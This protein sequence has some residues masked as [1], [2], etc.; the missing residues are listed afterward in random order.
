[1]LTLEPWVTIVLTTSLRVNLISCTVA[2]ISL[3]AFDQVLS[4]K[5]K[6]LKVIGGMGNLIGLKAK[7]FDNLEDGREV[8]LFFSFR[9]G[10]VVAEIALATVV[11]GEAEVDGD[12]FAMTD[13]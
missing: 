8:A 5:I 4:E 6:T 13:M 2:D 7:P 3:S 10:V 12:S 1:M 9:V 11:A